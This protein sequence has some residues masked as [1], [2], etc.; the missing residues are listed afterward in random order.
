MIEIVHKYTRHRV[1]PLLCCFDVS[2]IANTHRGS[3]GEPNNGQVMYKKGRPHLRRGLNAFGV[4]SEQ[5]YSQSD[6]NIASKDQ[7]N[8]GHEQAMSSPWSEEPIIHTCT[9]CK[10]NVRINPLSLTISQVH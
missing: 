10:K 9:M 4:E 7:V 2:C 5:K 8:A 1:T 3:A 6:A